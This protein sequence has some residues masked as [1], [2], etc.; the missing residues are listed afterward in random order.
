MGHKARSHDSQEG[1]GRGYG[2]CGLTGMGQR[3]EG[4]RKDQPEHITYMCKLSHNTI[5]KADSYEKIKM[6]SSSSLS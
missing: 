5:I 2:G 6:S 1:V 3:Q 4:A